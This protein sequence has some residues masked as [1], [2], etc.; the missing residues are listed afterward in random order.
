MYIAYHIDDIDG[1]W[2]VDLFC[3]VYVSVVVYEP[4]ISAKT[5]HTEC[6]GDWKSN[7][8]LFLYC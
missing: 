4:N 3:N 8:A 1:K 6:Y 7:F 2:N 5:L